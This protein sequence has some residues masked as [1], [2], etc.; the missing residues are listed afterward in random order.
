MWRSL[1]SVRA[2]NRYNI[3]P[4]ILD[5]TNIIKRPVTQLTLIIFINEI[6]PLNDTALCLC[7]LCYIYLH[8]AEL[9]CEALRLLS[10]TYLRAIYLKYPLPFLHCSWFDITCEV[11]DIY[12]EPRHADE[13]WN[14]SKQLSMSEYSPMVLVLWLMASG[15]MLMTFRSTSHKK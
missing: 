4:W 13:P 1:L 3:K 2:V 6:A 7:P 5:H 8:T 12:E 11:R 15:L 9:H 10:A 14:Q